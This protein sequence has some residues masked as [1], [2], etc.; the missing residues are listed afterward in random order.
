MENIKEKLEK[1]YGK[2]PFV[3]I[4]I[5]QEGLPF[6]TVEGVFTRL[7]I[8]KRHRLPYGCRAFSILHEY[9]DET[10]PSA[11]EYDAVIDH[12]GDIVCWGESRK[13]VENLLDNQ[14]Y[15]KI[16]NLKFPKTIQK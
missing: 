6:V 11:L 7:H 5:K 15:C 16:I 10:V 3:K 2:L 13:T 8:D 12:Y 9:G 4:R 14:C 1:E